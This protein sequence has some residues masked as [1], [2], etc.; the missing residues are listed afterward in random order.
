[1]MDNRLPLA[2]LQLVSD[3]NANWTTQQIKARIRNLET[4]GI[5]PRVIAEALARVLYDYCLEQCSKFGQSRTWAKKFLRDTGE[6]F[7]L[8]AEFSDLSERRVLQ[9]L[10]LLKNSDPK[11][12]A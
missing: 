12:S 5:P 8:T 1:M 9:E 7:L 10:K 6:D 3:P 4:Q 2:V 11:G